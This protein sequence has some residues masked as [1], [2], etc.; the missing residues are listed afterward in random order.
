MTLRAAILADLKARRY[1]LI[2]KLQ[3]AK[4]FDEYQMLF[5]RLDAVEHHLECIRIRDM[6]REG[7]GW[8]K[9]M[10]L[11]RLARSERETCTTKTRR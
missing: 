7:K 2:E 3:K 10:L 6:L 9:D 8:G 4:S 1:V 11:H 5:N